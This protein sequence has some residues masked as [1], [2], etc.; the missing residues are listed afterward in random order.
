MRFSNSTFAE[1]SSSGSL[2]CFVSGFVVTFKLLNCC[3]RVLVSSLT[4]DSWLVDTCKSSELVA[5]LVTVVADCMAINQLK[6][7]SCEILF[8]EVSQ[9]KYDKLKS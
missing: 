6:G 5:S 7:M 2:S 8:S 9:M 4:V 3:D 1:A